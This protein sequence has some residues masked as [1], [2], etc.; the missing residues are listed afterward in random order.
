LE[1]DDQRPSDDI[2][3][4]VLA[5]TNEVVPDGARRMTVRTPLQG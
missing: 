1:A 4:V 3:V 5:V 2:S